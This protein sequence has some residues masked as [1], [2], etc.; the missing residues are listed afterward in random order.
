MAK[1]QEKLRISVDKTKEVRI[2]GAETDLRLS[3]AARHAV[4]AVGEYNMPDGE[5]F[6]SVVEGSTQG[7]IT[8]TYPAINIG[9]EFHDIRLEFKGGKVVRA[10]A[11]KGEED[12]NKILDTDKGARRIGEIGF[13][14]NFKINRFTKDMLFDEK[15]GGTIHIALGRGYK[16]TKSLNESA[17]HW[18]MIKDL[19]EGGEI[20]FDDKLV[21]KNGR[22]L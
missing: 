11:S 9:R 15:I 22:W 8:F 10:T 14:N 3:I 5:V 20:W 4:S 18:D 12:L 1:D 6:T 16:E 21:Q 2:V 19:R 7:F 13:G 17:I